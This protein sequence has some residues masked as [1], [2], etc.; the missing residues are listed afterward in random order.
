MALLVMPSPEA[1]VAVAASLAFLLS[2]TL[3]QNL[4]LIH[5]CDLPPYNSHHDLYAVIIHYSPAPALSR[6]QRFYR[7]GSE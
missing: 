1:I 7:P 2:S 3:R 5:L 4:A 6:R